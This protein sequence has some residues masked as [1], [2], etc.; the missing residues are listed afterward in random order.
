KNG[1]EGDRLSACGVR[2]DAVRLLVHSVA[3]DVVVLFREAVR[4]VPEVATASVT[5]LR[6]RL[7]KVGAVLRVG[8]RRVWLQVAAAWPHREL[9]QRG[10]AAVQGLASPARALAGGAGGP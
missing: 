9:W 5:T 8:A 6:Q 3:Y 1:V 4:G 10:W 7:W 2:A